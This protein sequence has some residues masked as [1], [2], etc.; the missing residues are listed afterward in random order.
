MSNEDLA[1][2]VDGLEAVQTRNS[3]PRLTGS[4]D[5]SQLQDILKAGLRAPDHAQLRPWRI[6]VIRDEA[7]DHLGDLFVTA[8]LSDDPEQ[9]EKAIRKLRHKPHR[10]PVILVVIARITAHPQVPEMEQILSAGAVAQNM[11]IAAHA[12]G[13]GAMWRTGGMSYHPV[14]ESGLGLDGS[15]KIVGFVYLGEVDGRQK[16]LPEMDLEQYVTY[17]AGQD[18]V[19][20]T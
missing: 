18:L 19:S 5:E 6:L 11:L 12:L 20:S 1:T 9:P 14:V 10:A 13:L 15:E 2:P 3:A 4:V 8:K 7:R 17:W 16:S